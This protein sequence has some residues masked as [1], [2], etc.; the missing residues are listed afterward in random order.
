MPQRVDWHAPVGARS[1]RPQRRH[2][3]GG[4]GRGGSGFATLEFRVTDACL[5]VDDTV[6]VAALVRALV[7]TCHA[8]VLSGE[9]PPLPRVELMRLATWRAARFGLDGDLVDAVAERSLPATELL[10]TLLDCVRWDLEQ[11]DEWAVVS[12]LVGRVIK[13]GT[14]AARQRRAFER[15]G[16]WR[17]LSTWWSTPRPPRPAASHD[18]RPER[19]LR[20][21]SAHAGTRSSEITPRST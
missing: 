12:D 2:L 1:S 17:T 5:T 16:P 3:P 6:T 14:G 7:R 18:N 13:A 10:Q 8:K 9:E 21:P 19:A 4:C 20:R 15:A 11:H